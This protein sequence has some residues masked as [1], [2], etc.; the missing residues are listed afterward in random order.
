MNDKK[1]DQPSETVMP[2]DISSTK[3]N[4]EETPVGKTIG[5]VLRDERERK[6]LSYAQVSEITKVRQTFLK[7]LESEA[8]D[9]LPS[10]AFVSG[11]IRSYGRVLGLNEKELMALYQETGPVKI[12]PPKPL[13]KPARSHKIS[14]TML[15]FLLLAISSIYFLWKGYSD[16]KAPDVAPEKISATEIEP[17]KIEKTHDV[18]NRT[19]T[20]IP[21]TQ[22]QPDET[23]ETLDNPESDQKNSDLLENDIEPTK[24]AG[25]AEPAEIVPQKLVLKA[26]IREETW[27]KIF[28]DDKDPREYIFQPGRR[29]QWTAEEGFKLMIGNARGIDLELNGEEVKKSMTPGKVVHLTLPENYER[30]R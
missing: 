5:S 19:T 22:T 30:E 25:P 17:K 6:G 20:E 7:A 13:V 14:F 23:I 2:E 28:I 16:Q 24:D 8:W 29:Y 15:V 3:K 12:A 27:V 18:Q 26:R 1:H 21:S 4:G 9:D 11:F 10:P